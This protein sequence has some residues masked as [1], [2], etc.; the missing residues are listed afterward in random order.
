MMKKIIMLFLLTLSA[1]GARA[2]MLAV[3]TDLLMDALMMPSVGAEMVVGERSVVGLH[4]FGCYKPWGKQVKSVGVQPEYRWFFSGRPMYHF[5][6]G[7]GAIA[8][9]YDVTWAGKVYNG[10][11][12]GAGLTFGYVLPLS[13]RANVDFHAGFGAIYYRQKEYFEGK[14]VDYANASGYTL[15]P[16]R[17]GISLSYI[18]K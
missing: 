3:G 16:T 14:D 10:N 7:A 11:A 2:Q 13:K 15:L 1:F 17:I 4:A 8:T 18:L 6:V 5:F 12:A 9:A